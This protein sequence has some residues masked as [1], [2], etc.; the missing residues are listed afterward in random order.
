MF[1]ELFQ[2]ARRQKRLPFATPTLEPDVACHFHPLLRA[3]KLGTKPKRVVLN[4]R[5]IVLYRD[6]AGVPHA[7]ADQC[8]HR[9]S[10][11][12]LG[13]VRPDGR[14][15]CGYHGWHFDEHGHGQ[16]PTVQK[17]KCRTRSYQVVEKLGFLWVADADV[18]LSAL[19]EFIGYAESGTGEWE[20]MKSI[21]VI[22]ATV[23]APLTVVVDNFAEVEH[24]PYLHRILGW[25]TGTQNQ[26]QVVLETENLPDRTEAFVTAP[27]RTAAVGPM[28]PFDGV[29]AK[30]AR[31]G[32]HSL[33]YYGMRFS[34]VHNSFQLGWGDP[35]E[36]K[37]R[38]MTMR[39][40]N[41]FVPESRNRTHMHTFAFMKI[42]D[43]LWQPFARVLHRMACWRLMSEL[44]N[45]MDHVEQIGG[46]PYQL[47]GMRLSRSDKQLVH[48]RK[49]LQSIYYKTDVRDEP[50]AEHEVLAV[51]A[52]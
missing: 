8:P 15:A 43:P 29:L 49:L 19:P 47:A 10:S 14:L 33:L 51:S 16:C 50:T 37:F 3:N 31:P 1:S 6:A 7:L 26:G 46:S 21:G 44:R 9:R 22:S 32:E 20:G 34:P 52:E 48:I 25:D 40:T 30:L 45:D 23:D 27:Q 12:S 13:Q 2:A 17:L 11:L 39:A 35:K 28:L 5:A 41:V 38:H 36:R 24:V 4:E 42:M 18:P